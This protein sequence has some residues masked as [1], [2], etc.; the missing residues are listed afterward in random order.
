MD[1]QFERVRGSELIVEKFQ[2]A[3]LYL[4][5]KQFPIIHKLAL[6]FDGRKLPSAAP[7]LLRLKASTMGTNRVIQE[8]SA[9]RKTSDSRG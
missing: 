4:D 8:P 3:S 6:E 9:P 2:V 5:P 7:S 1:S